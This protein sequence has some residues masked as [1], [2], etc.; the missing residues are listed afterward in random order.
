MEN[1]IWPSGEP[2]RVAARDRIP[3]GVP[4][5]V[6]G[7]QDI[8]LFDKEEGGLFGSDDDVLGSVTISEDDRGMGPLSKLAHSEEEHS[9]YY[10][11]YH[12]D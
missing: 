7:S 6:E 2:V 3:V 8:F 11:N 12:V 4:I 1:A 10:V 9:F 5:T